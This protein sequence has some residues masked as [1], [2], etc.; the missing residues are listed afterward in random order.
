MNKTVIL[1][2]ML[3]VFHMFVLIMKQ[4]NAKFVAFDMLIIILQ[5]VCALI[6]FKDSTDSD[7]IY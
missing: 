2:I 1:C 3:A 6:A 7:D 5:I 4:L